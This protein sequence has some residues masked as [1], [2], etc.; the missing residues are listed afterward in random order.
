MV[1]VFWKNEKNKFSFQDQTS[2][3]RFVV[4]AVGQG[5]V[6]ISQLFR[7][8]HFNVDRK[9]VEFDESTENRRRGRI[10]ETCVEMYSRLQ[11]RKSGHRVEISARRLTQAS[12]R[13]PG[14]KLARFISTIHNSTFSKF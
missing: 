10:C 11:R 8:I 4:D 9:F 7:L 5:R 3:C 12:G 1:T 14:N 13:Q 6:W 2:S